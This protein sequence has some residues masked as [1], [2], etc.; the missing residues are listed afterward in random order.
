[1]G[2][3]F[4]EVVSVVCVLLTLLC[5]VL[6]KTPFLFLY[7]TFSGGYD[8]HLVTYYV[9]LLTTKPNTDVCF[10][11][12]LKYGVIP[13]ALWRRTPQLYTNYRHRQ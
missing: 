13:P 12:Q 10:A 2:A 8:D 6:S 1:M 9:V 11:T 4:S 3:S 5:V 7:T